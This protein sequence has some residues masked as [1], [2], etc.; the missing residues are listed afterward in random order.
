MMGSGTQG[1]EVERMRMS[2]RQVT[3]RIKEAV[4]SRRAR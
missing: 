3:T 2:L 4:L 1:E